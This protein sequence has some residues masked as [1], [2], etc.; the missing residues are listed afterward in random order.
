VRAFAIV[1]N[2]ATGDSISYQRLGDR[3][4]ARGASTSLPATTVPL[5]ERSTSNFFPAGIHIQLEVRYRGSLIQIWTG[6]PSG[7]DTYTNG[8]FFPTFT[9]RASSC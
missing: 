3:R 4:V 5:P 2:T 7:Y 9:G 1:V 8:A 6:I